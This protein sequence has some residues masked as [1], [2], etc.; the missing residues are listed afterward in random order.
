MHATMDKIV[1]MLLVVTGRAY[2]LDLFGEKI[3]C[4]IHDI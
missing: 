4:E 1:C 2:T 3:T